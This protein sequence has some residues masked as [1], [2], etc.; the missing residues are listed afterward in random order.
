MAQLTV[1]LAV[2]TEQT[3]RLLVTLTPTSIIIVPA[4][5]SDPM[6]AKEY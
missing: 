3:R 1:P 2:P 4:P 5:S 6:F